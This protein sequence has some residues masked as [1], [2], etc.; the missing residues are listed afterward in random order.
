MQKKK[1][2]AYPIKI[3]FAWGVAIGGDTSI[4]S[5]LIEHGYK[6]LGLFVYALH[7]KQDA[8]DWLLKNQPHLMALINA[9]ED[10]KAALNWLEQH[11]YTA[12]K[13]LALAALEEERSINWLQQNGQKELLF[14][15]QQIGNVKTQ[16]EMSH[17]DVHKISREV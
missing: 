16:I 15:A 1:L 6:E 7:L 2:K 12:L 4:R 14:V 5:W 11:D 9:V 13:H 8:R 17:N 3:L 10:N